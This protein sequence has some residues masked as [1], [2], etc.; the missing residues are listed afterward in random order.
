MLL[1]FGYSNVQT[2]PLGGNKISG[3]YIVLESKNVSW[4]APIFAYLRDIKIFGEP[5]LGNSGKKEH[6]WETDFIDIGG[7]RI[8][9][10]LKE[11][12]NIKVSAG[13]SN[14]LVLYHTIKEYLD[15]Y[16]I[17]DIKFQEGNRRFFLISG[18]TDVADVSKKTG[19]RR[20]SDINLTGQFSGTFALSLKE[21]KFPSWETVETYWKDK[22]NVL[23]YAIANQKTKVETIGTEFSLSQSI[24]VKCKPFEAQSVIF[25]SD[26]HDKGL[27][28]TQTWKSG[29]FDWDYKNRTL[30]IE[31][32]DIIHAM[33][34]VSSSMWPYFQLRNHS[35]HKSKFLPGVHA[36]AVPFDNLSSKDVILPESSRTYTK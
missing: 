16:K 5:K 18:V 1:S 6:T 27:I 22:H 26:I 29:N 9:A 33:S 34:D 3:F 17:I 25:G 12:K 28:L 31:T 24:A 2:L 11:L 4:R 19:E 32:V 23:A 10:G 36:L 20:K 7:Y 21:K 30:I 35:G 13:K 14:E 8:T 15:Q